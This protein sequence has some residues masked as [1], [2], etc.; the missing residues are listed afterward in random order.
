MLCGSDVLTKTLIL[1]PVYN[2][3]KTLPSFFRCLY[4]LNPQPNLYV[5]VE[6]NSSDDTLQQ[7]RR[8]KHPHKIIRVW[9]RKDAAMCNT[10]RYIPIAHIRQLL[11]TFARN[12]NPDYAIFLDSDVF[13]RTKELIDNLTRWRKDIVGGG[14]LRVFPDAMWLASKWKHPNQSGY[15]FRRKIQKTLDE[16]WITSAGCMCLSQRIIQDKRINFFPVIPNASEDFGYCLQAREHGYKVFLDGVIKLE[17]YI[18]EKIPTKPWSRNSITQPYEQFFYEDN[19]TNALLN[20]S[21]RTLKIGLLSTR[22]FGVPPSGYSGLEQVVWDLACALDKLG[23]EVTLFAPTGSR[24]PPHGK[25]VETGEVYQTCKIN[26]LGAELE[27]Y[28]FFKD[29]VDDLD[30]LHG[31]NWYGIEY[32]KKARNLDLL[33][34][35]THHGLNVSWLNMF[36]SLF[37]LNLISVSDWTKGVFAKQGFNAKRCY[38]GINIDRYKFKPEKQERLMFLGRISRSKAPHIAVKVAKEAGAELDIIGSTTFVEDSDYVNEVKK[39]CDGKHIR[40]IGEVIHEEKIEY[41]Q[42]AM[43]L[44]IPS[45]FGEPFGL[46]SIEAMACGTIP[47]AL[48]DGALRE[49]INDG[50]NGFICKSPDQMVARIKELELID[51]KACRARAEEFSREKMAQEYVKLYWQMINGQEW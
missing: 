22:F 43:G 48:D 12:Y 38:N 33:V 19:N 2:C 4:D 39:L 23:H 5:F 13:P 40:F 6:N 29:H 32:L 26:W 15:E 36:K 34:A 50:K 21:S 27:A 30:I 46:I 24:P 42:N 41:L 45:Q 49:V 3:T 35:H 9:F 14:Y 44:L 47:V 20:T 28:D 31:H 16:P 18:P 51:P 25:L 10:N 17:H 37:K 11:L 1:V 7:V 8:F